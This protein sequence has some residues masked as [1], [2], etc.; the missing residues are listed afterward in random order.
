MMRECKTWDQWVKECQAL[1][2]LEGPHKLAMDDGSY[3]FINGKFGGT[4]A[5]WNGPAHRGFI[6][7]QVN[8]GSG[9]APT[10]SVAPDGGES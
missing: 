2:N 1:A 4:A 7:S 9:I 10:V 8:E 6:F 3:Q 5:I